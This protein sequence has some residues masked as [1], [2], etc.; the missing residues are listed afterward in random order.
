MMNAYQAPDVDDHDRVGVCH[1]PGRT[2]YSCHLCRGRCADLGGLYGANGSDPKGPAANFDFVVEGMGLGTPLEARSS[3][4]T[5][6]VGMELKEAEED[7]E[8]PLAGD[9]GVDPGVDPGEQK[10]DMLAD[11]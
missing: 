11:S 10:Y 4:S 5:G 1:Y 6:L 8:E 2:A 7:L 9:P 3:M